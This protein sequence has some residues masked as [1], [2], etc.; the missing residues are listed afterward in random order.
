MQIN[1]TRRIKREPKIDYFR[2]LLFK[3]EFHDAVII[4][5]LSPLTKLINAKPRTNITSRPIY[6]R[7]PFSAQPI[8]QVK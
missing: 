6:S 4:R 1:R 3:N 7:P 5:P 8:V 2:S